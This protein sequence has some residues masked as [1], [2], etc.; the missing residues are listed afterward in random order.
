MLASENNLRALKKKVLE[1]NPEPSC[2]AECA[3]HS[4]VSSSQ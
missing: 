3:E 1:S 4:T 2:S